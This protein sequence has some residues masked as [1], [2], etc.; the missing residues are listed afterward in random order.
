M[1]K[2]IK[3][4]AASVALF[5]LS[6]SF[7]MQYV[8]KLEPCPLC[9]FQR[10]FMMILAVI[11]IFALIHH[12]KR[13]G[14]YIYNGLT[15]ILASLGMLVSAYHVYAQQ[16]AQQMQFSCGPDFSFIL[17]EDGALAALRS[18]FESPGHCSDV[19]WQ[20]L[21]LSIPAWTL[22]LFALLLMLSLMNIYQARKG[23]I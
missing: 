5:G 7:F 3:F 23:T 22:L 4:L 1:T 2:H 17:R 9:I 13:L 16:K 10:I 8:M 18:I 19:H 14:T 12:T 6:A 15:S 11:F 21:G 20:F